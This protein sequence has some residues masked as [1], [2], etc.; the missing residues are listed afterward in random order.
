MLAGQTLLILP[1]LSQFIHPSFI[2]N[3]LSHS[4]I[5]LFTVLWMPLFPLPS[6]T[7]CCRSFISCPGRLLHYFSF[8]SPSVAS[9]HLSL[10]YLIHQRPAGRRNAVWKERKSEVRHRGDQGHDEA[11]W[12]RWRLTFRASAAIKHTHTVKIQASFQTEMKCEKKQLWIAFERVR[13]QTWCTN[14]DGV[15]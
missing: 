10:S 13:T 6:M 8:L 9:Q 14:T 7:S 1:S 2:F 15:N 5:L 3:T 12:D 11:G 4:V